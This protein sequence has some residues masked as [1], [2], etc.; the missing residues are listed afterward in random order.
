MSLVGKERSDAMLPFQQ[1]ILVSIDSTKEL[2]EHIKAVCGSSYL[3]TTPPN[4]DICENNFSQVKGI[5]G[6]F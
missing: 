6:Q 5:G 2:Y 4:N 1:G 3:L